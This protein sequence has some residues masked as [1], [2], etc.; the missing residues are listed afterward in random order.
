[1]LLRVK[2][3]EHLFKVSRGSGILNATVNK[4]RHAVIGECYPLQTT[5]YL[6]L[7]H[8]ARPFMTT[9]GAG[10]NISSHGVRLQ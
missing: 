4:W 6:T 7:S 5:Y 3:L 10:L 2:I 1:M 8:N 9:M